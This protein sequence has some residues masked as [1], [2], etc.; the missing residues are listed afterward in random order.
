MQPGESMPVMMHLAGCSECAAKYDRLDRKIREAA[1]CPAEKPETFWAGQR[2]AIVRRVAGSQPAR[3]L[4]APVRVAAA[5]ALAFTVAGFVA[6]RSH[7]APEP[8]PVTTAAAE[9][10]IPADPWQS[11]PLQQYQ[12]VVE[13]ESWVE[14]GKL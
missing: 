7:Q 8:A 12:P 6:Y 13:W 4:R 9:R 11:E 3:R 10:A 5:A 1:A 14:E 2:Q